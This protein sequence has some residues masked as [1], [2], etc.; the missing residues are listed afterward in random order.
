MPAGPEG[1]FAGLLEGD[2]RDIATYLLAQPPID[3][4]VAPSCRE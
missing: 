4:P 3:N 1:A 2:L